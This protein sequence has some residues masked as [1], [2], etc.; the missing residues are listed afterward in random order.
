MFFYTSFLDIAFATGKLTTY[1]KFLI[2]SLCTVICNVP[3]Q[4]M[5]DKQTKKMQ[6]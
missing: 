2:V 6:Q 5:E 1:L 4:T 3:E